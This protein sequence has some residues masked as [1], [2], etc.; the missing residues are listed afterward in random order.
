[1]RVRVTLALSA[2]NLTLEG[3]F[4][5]HSNQTFEATYHLPFTRRDSLSTTSLIV[6]TTYTA[7]SYTRLD[8]LESG[9][10]TETRFHLT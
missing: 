9:H 5:K 7:T 6:T 8:T 4:T 2:R 1:V 3:A 10:T